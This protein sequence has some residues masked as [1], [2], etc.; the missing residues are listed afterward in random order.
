MTALATSKRRFKCPVCERTIERQ[1]RTQVYCSP[2]CMRKGNYALKK[3]PRYTPSGDVRTHHF[4]PSENN[5][6]QWPKT[7]SSTGAKPVLAD[8]I[9]G[10]RN[11]IQAEVIAGRK[12]EEVV[13]SSGV[14]SYV[15]PLTTRALRDEKPQ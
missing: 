9:V 4:F 11:V 1:S 3:L 2:K 6:L 14:K 12:W 5:I 8:G 7:G 10:P 13:S 15:S